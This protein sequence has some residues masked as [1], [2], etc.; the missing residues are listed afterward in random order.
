MR[1]SAGIGGVPS[2]RGSTS[3]EDQGREARSPSGS[4]REQLDARPDRRPAVAP[5]QRDGGDDAPGPR[6]RGAQSGAP[7]TRD[8]VIGPPTFSRTLGNGWHCTFLCGRFGCHGFGTLTPVPLI[9]AVGGTGAEYS[10]PWHPGSQGHLPLLSS[11]GG[12]RGGGVVAGSISGRSGSSLLLNVT[13]SEATALPQL[14]SQGERAEKG[15]NARTRLMHPCHACGRGHLPLPQS[16]HSSGG[17]LRWNC[18]GTGSRSIGTR[19]SRRLAAA[20]LLGDA[21]A[22]SSRIG[23]ATM[24]LGDSAWGRAPWSVA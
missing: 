19:E 8:G 14:L 24:V 10:N 18:E 15:R 7:Q 12:G 5:E 16:V 22:G 4:P 17:P 9:A 20:D 21:V 1:P 23:S 13:I 11:R 6:R 3:R 2:R